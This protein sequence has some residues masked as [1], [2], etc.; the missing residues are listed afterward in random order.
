MKQGVH[1]RNTCQ[2]L[3]KNRTKALR[4][5]GVC[6]APHTVILLP[7]R[8]SFPTGAERSESRRRADRRKNSSGWRKEAWR[9]P[10]RPA[11]TS[12]TQVTRGEIKEFSSLVAAQSRIRKRPLALFPVCEPLRLHRT[13][14]TIKQAAW[15]VPGLQGKRS[16]ERR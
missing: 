10:G 11:Q 2:D 12:P 4:L 9:H 15:L 14:Q 8:A 13:L 16:G 3:E 5:F 6:L 7:S 1:F